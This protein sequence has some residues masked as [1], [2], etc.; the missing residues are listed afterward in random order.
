MTG[1]ILGMV[2]LEL[3]MAFTNSFML[4]LNIHGRDPMH[5]GVRGSSGTGL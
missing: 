2:S 3:G 1:A 5:D 4:G